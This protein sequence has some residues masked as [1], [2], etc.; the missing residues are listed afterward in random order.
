L[1][2]TIETA[3]ALPRPQ[4]RTRQLIRDDVIAITSLFGTARNAYRCLA[5]DDG[6]VVDFETFRRLLG[7]GYARNEEVD[8]VADAW[9]TWR[10]RFIQPEMLTSNSFRLEHP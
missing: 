10:A 9:I 7:W 4:V 2:L 3:T 6:G 1:W 8:A 5:L